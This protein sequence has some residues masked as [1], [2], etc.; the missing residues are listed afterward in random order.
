MYDPFLQELVQINFLPICIIAFLGLYLWF[1]DA[2]ERELTRYFIV[3]MI[4][5]GILVL[6]DNIDYYLLNDSNIGTW[7]VAIVVLGYNVRI[8]LMLSL[9]L[10]ELRSVNKRVKAWLFLPAIVNLLITCCAFFTHWVFWY[11]EDATLMRGPL[12]YTP[13][14]ISFLYAIILLLYGLYILR[15]GRWQ[16]SVIVCTATILSVLGTLVETIFQLR[17]ILIGVIALDV[18]FFYLYFHIEFFKMDILT[19]TLNRISFY[20]ESKGL[21]GR[22]DVT[23][24]S[25]DLNDLKTLNDTRGHTEGDKAL[26][27]V[28]RILRAHL[29]KGCRLYRVGGD[30]FV[31]IGAGVVRES[32]DGMEKE[33]QEELEKSPYSFSLGWAHMEKGESFESVY[34]RADQQMYRN[35]MALKAARSKK[36]G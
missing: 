30:E 26:R 25:I 24:Y 32:L 10:I 22:D 8:C 12:A 4:L 2:Y 31:I 6:H 28:A 3:P 15:Y 27:E 16:E 9:V 35:K 36:N 17:G 5:L 20:T 33:L 7:H 19:G 34:S 13:H 14:A 21:S 18:T 1:N 23:V 11:A 29:P